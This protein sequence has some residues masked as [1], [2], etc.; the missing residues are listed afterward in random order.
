LRAAH[1]EIA[2]VGP[3]LNS[4]SRRSDSV[5]VKD[6]N[7]NPSNAVR[8]FEGGR[9]PELADGGGSSLELRD[10]WA[11]NS[12]AEAWTASREAVAASWSHHTYRA[13]A[14]PAPG[15]TLEGICARPARCW[16]MS[17]R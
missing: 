16:R 1:P 3:F 9:W 5:L 10:P 8:Y 7:G 4:L 14:S 12:V 11:D 2:V 6:A 13:V 15:P 17:D